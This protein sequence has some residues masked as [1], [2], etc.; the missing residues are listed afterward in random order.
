MSADLV[1]PTHDA[2][3]V[4]DPLAMVLNGINGAAAKAMLDKHNRAARAFNGG[5]SG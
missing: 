5:T 2:R 1:A 4:I 3:L